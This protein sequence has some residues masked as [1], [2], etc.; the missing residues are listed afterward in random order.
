VRDTDD[1][2][3]D[4]GA[5]GEVCLRSPAVMSGYWR[6]PEQTAAAFTADGF[7]RTGDLGWIDDRGRLRLVGRSKEMYVRGGYNVYPVEVES[8][9]STHP[10]IAA[11]AIVPRADNVMGEVGVA[12]VVPRDSKHVPTLDELRAFAGTQVAA[13]KLPEAL[14]VRTDLPLTAGEKVDRRALVAELGDHLA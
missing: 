7:V 3:V 11:V 5:V 10:D 2:A 6:D 13:Y 8:V 9:L 4:A 12:V 1:R 14:V